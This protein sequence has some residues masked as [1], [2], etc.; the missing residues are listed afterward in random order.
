VAVCPDCK[1]E[2]EASFCPRDGT[3]L[4]S[5]TG[6]IVADRYRLIRKVGEGAMGEVY[7]AEHLHLQR[8]V[9]VKLLQRKISSDPE[10]RAR[11]QREARST[12]GLGHPNVVDTI[13]FGFAADGQPFLVMEWLDGENLDA[14]ISRGLLDVTTALDIAQQACAGLAAAHARGIVHRDLKP[15]NLFLTR[16]HRNAL[17]VKVLD[18]GIA[19]LRLHET[20]LTATGVLIGTPSYMAPEQ[21]E[22]SAVDARTDVYALGVILYEMLIGAVP[23]DGDTPLSVLHQ[24]TSRPPPSL[25]AR[26]PERAISEQLDAIVMRCLAKRPD[27]RF[28]TMHELAA[29]IAAA[30]GATARSASGVASTTSTA[31]SAAKPLPT[32][33]PT[34][35][36]PDAIRPNAAMGDVAA[37]TRRTWVV[38]AL[39][40]TIA[41]AGAAAAYVLL[42]HSGNT[43]QR[44][45]GPVAP[46]GSAATAV[47][48]AAV[49]SPPADAALET[50]PAMPGVTY[51]LRGHGFTGTIVARPSV[52]IA[53]EPVELAIELTPFESELRDAAKAGKVTATIELR[54]FKDHAL[55]AQ[56]SHVLDESARFTMVPRLPRTGRHHVHL[57]L[58]VD[59][60]EVDHA[61][62][63]L[64]R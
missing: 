43:A 35:H 24:H 49:A 40:G 44:D 29:A 48:D 45:A 33:P 26:A 20:K 60:K 27:D 2:F 56:S 36:A 8:R 51:A 12:T 32:I 4:I 59:G 25:L 7:E 21:A 41:I 63:D 15:A 28:A 62:L 31:S 47:S 30:G 23:F 52:P 14:R 6:S 50:P 17:L 55:V 9:A 38:P 1:G 42:G 57:D 3:R 61:T 37:T 13:D 64:F 39:L 22:G 54:Y 34:F 19:K 10:V 5:A 58:L 53:G 16:D 11:F 18:F 46:A